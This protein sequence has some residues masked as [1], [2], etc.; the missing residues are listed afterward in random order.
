M[1][2]WPCEDHRRRSVKSPGSYDST[3]RLSTCGPDALAQQVD[4]HA[5]SPERSP[6]APS[7]Q[8][9]STTRRQ[10]NRDCP[11]RLADGFVPRFL[12]ASQRVHR[13]QT[14]GFAGTGSLCSLLALRDDDRQ[15]GVVSGLEAAGEVKIVT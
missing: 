15:C 3:L 7:M 14:H 1:D 9:E 11:G 4:D 2:T 5:P 10:R 6:R 12:P 13:S 8:R